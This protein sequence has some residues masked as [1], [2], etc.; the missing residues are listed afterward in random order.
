MSCFNCKYKATLP[1]AVH[2]IRKLVFSF[3]FYI[4]TANDC[5]NNENLARL[6]WT[7]KELHEYAV[8][9]VCCILCIHTG[10]VY[11]WLKKKRYFQLKQPTH[12][13][14]SAIEIITECLSGMQA[15]YLNSSWKFFMKCFETKSKTNQNI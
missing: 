9:G 12:Q 6:L 5:Q 2:P 15:Y 14:A 3:C 13:C 7:V 8:K 11:V 10:W 1:H 4:S